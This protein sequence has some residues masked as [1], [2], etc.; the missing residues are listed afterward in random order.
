MKIKA[1]KGVND[2]LPSEV[3]NWTYLENLSRRLF[4][5]YAFREIRVPIIEESALFTRSIGEQTDIVEKEMY[6]FV[7][8]GKRKIALRPEAT[9]SVVRAYLEHGLD[10]EGIAKLF[11]IGPMF[12]GEKPQSGRN[13][14][15]YQIGAEVLGSDSPYQDAEVIDIAIEFLKDLNLKNYKLHINSVGCPN[16]KHKFSQTLKNYLLDKKEKLCASCQNRYERN[17]LRI[18]DCKNPGC[19]SILQKAPDISSHFCSDC[20]EHFTQVRTS[21]DALDIPYTVLPHLVR[22]LDYYTKTVFEINHKGLGAQDAICAG[23]RYDTLI[24]DLGGATQGACGFSFGIERLLLAAAAE[25]I[26]FEKEP[27]Q[28]VYMF[29]LGQKAQIK[30]LALAQSL[31]KDG[32]CVFINHEQKPLKKLLRQADKAAYKFVLILGEDELSQGVITLKNMQDG[33]QQP[34]KLDT[35]ADELNKILRK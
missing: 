25:K 14:Q 9:A 27:A 19:K 6:T 10:S 15:F 18:L 1:L 22:G 4:S 21:L 3:N 20:T 2:I 8:K 28:A 33:T 35:I 24:S 30:I 16:D 32:F 7:D 13:R 12:R 17:L 23:G 29:S 11:Y 26:A 34:L 5:Q 31:R